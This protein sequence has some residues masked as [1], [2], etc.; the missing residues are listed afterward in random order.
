MVTEEQIHG[1][2]RSIVFRNDSN[3]Y[4]IAKASSGGKTVT[5]VGS[6]PGIAVGGSCEFI[7]SWVVHPKYG[8]QFAV[9]S[10]TES[11]P[12]TT[13]DVISFLSSGILR[14]VGLKTAK[15]IVDKFGDETMDVLEN[16]P[17]RLLLVEGIGEKKLKDITA[18]YEERKDFAKV[19][20]AFSAYGISPAAALKL[21]QEYGASATEAVKEN[22]YRMIDEVSGIGF[23][24]A[25]G[26]AMRM[27]VASDSAYRIQSGV[28][29]ILSRYA[30]D[31]NT[32]IPLTELK[33][34]TVELLDVSGDQTEDAVFALE[35]IGKADK[36]KING[37]DA[38][39]LSRFYMAELASATNLKRLMDAEPKAIL[40]DADSLIR[41][42]EERSGIT[43]SEKQKDAV[44]NSLRCGV[45]V[46][47]GGPG[48]GKTTII[49]SIIDILTHC[50]LETVIAAPTGRAAKRITETTGYGAST[51]H[52]L[53]EYT[54]GEDDENL[55]FGRNAENTLEC[56]AVVIDEASM[57]DVILMKALTDAIPL[58]A[59]LIIVGDAD[60]LP[61]VGAGNVLHDVLHSERIPCSKLTDVFRQAEESMIVVNAHRINRGDYPYINEADSDF[62]LLR[63][64]GEQ[65]ILD[66][67]TE[68]CAERLP[69]HYGFNAK[70]DIQILT[71]VR[72]GA[73]GC[74]N[75][76]RIL[77]HILNP[78]DPLNA[79][80][81][82]GERIFREGDRVMQTKNNYTLKWVSTKDF[83]EGEGVFN[84]DMGLISE[85]NEDKGILAVLYEDVKRAEYSFADLDQVEHAYAVTVHKSQGSEFPAVIMPVFAAPPMLSTRN[86]IYT[87]VTRGKRLVVLVGSEDRLHA[88]VDNNSQHERYSAMQYFLTG[89][90][91]RPW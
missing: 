73:L 55:A 90:G 14:G 7:G 47:T 65:S 46:I 69:L 56:D 10:Y 80:K 19:V 62:F 15:A 36:K 54:Y 29:Y 27:G 5:V 30:S 44:K 83:S 75:L 77:Q 22:P 79:E 26:I 91:D 45:F 60:Q 25:D 6:L 4:T 12:E 41:D 33:E 72:K 35:M 17:R 8:E 20:L 9:S 50:G 3:G 24:T 18:S 2:I 16:H 82:F 13:D 40:A 23:R 68:L 88:M 86:L 89:S 71:P 51:I 59:R 58:G 49:K 57:I 37:T 61:S 43:L 39:F 52:R 42:T 70:K 31:G 76:N 34:R 81:T 32:Y 11:E 63:R 87:A 28:E 66:A 53:L 48:T 78:P 64:T 84:G 21:Y 38:V 67:V 74:L 85:V 1:T